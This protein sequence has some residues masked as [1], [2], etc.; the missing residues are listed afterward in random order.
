[1]ITTEDVW[2]ETKRLVNNSYEKIRQ[3]FLQQ[4]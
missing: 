3:E 2:T 1:M 4:V